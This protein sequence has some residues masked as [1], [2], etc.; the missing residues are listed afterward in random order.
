MP[1]CYLLLY[2]V[3]GCPLASPRVCSCLHW[4]HKIM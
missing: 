3:L 2:T 1:A 4:Q